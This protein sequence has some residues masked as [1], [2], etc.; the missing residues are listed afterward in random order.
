MT[1]RPVC[2]LL[3]LLALALLLSGCGDDEKTAAPHPWAGK[4]YLLEI[5]PE[6]WSEPPNIGEE[7][8]QFVPQFMLLVESVSGD[9]LDVAVG[10]ANAGTQQMCNPTTSV[11][12]V[13]AAVPEVQIGP[14]DFPIYLRDEERD[15]TV[16]GTARELTFTNILPDGDIPADEGVISASIDTRDICP[17]IYGS[18]VRTPE[19]DCNT[20]AEFGAPC[21]PCPHDDAPYCVQIK[22]TYL[23]ATES[24]AA[25]Q[26]VEAGSIDSS[27]CQDTDPGTCKQ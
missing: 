8:G 12:G 9:T 24:A 25:L 22:A 11:Q 15:V 3:P 21:G 27:S 23:G 14:F 1:K 4:T 19:A 5:A 26:P 20:L 13:S 10:T 2:S 16:N 7:I 17:L 6:A 18:F